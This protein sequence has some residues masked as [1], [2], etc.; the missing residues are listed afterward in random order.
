MFYQCQETQ[1]IVVVRLGALIILHPLEEEFHHLNKHILTRF[2][3]LLTRF[4]HLLDT[5]AKIVH[6]GEIFIQA[7]MSLLEVLFRMF[8]TCLDKQL[9]EQGSRHLILRMGIIQLVSQRQR[10]FKSVVH[11][12]ELQFIQFQLEEFL[13]RE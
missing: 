8:A 11:E 3:H 12:D 7:L 1:R 6:F 4:F 10:L 13:F 2:F 9:C 5:T